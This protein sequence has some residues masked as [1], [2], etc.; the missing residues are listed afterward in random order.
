MIRRP[1]GS[2]RPDTLFPYTSLFRSDDA[3]ATG[4]NAVAS[5]AGSVAA[6]YRSVA[7]GHHAQAGDQ[8][9]I[10]GG[11]ESTATG[12]GDVALGANAKAEGGSSVAIGGAFDTFAGWEYNISAERREG[13]QRVSTGNSRECAY[14]E[15]QKVKR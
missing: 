5:G 7:S 2:T 15:T 1:P 14:Q 8:W 9:G 6:G 10:A 3:Q 11:S 13:K 4:D 12:L